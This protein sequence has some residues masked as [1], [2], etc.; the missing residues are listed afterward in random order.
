MKETGTKINEIQ[1][2]IPGIILLSHG[3]LAS[4]LLGTMEMVLGTVDNVTALEL[5]EGDHP[6]KYRMR[7]AEIAEAMPE[8]SVFLMDIFG[9][10]PFNQVIQYFLE[11]GKEIRAV[12]GMNL[13][14]LLRISG[15]LMLLLLLA[16]IL[17]Q[18]KMWIMA[19]GIEILIF[20]GYQ[21]LNTGIEMIITKEVMTFIKSYETLGKKEE[22]E[23]ERFYRSI[24]FAEWAVLWKGIW[25]VLSLI[26]K[27]PGCLLRKRGGEPIKS[28]ER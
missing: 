9:G 15:P 8:K 3:P 16:G 24:E 20:L 21:L 17:L 2:D 26:L 6:E 11:N 25:S 5:E 10:S 4:G 18:N 19:A 7:I 14:M 12:S 27:L 23:A 1:S 22:K 13:G 28:T